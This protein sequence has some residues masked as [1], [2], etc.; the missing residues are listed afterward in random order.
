MKNIIKTIYIEKTNQS[1]EYSDFLKAFSGMI[2]LCKEMKI[3]NKDN[4]ISYKGICENWY[5]FDI[6]LVE[7]ISNHYLFEINL[8][9]QEKCKNFI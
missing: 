7:R 1:P 9:F 2:S 6:N 8:E 5:I 3:F 4:P